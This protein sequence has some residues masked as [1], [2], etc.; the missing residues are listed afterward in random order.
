MYDIGNMLNSRQQQQKK[1][2]QIMIMLS[3]DFLQSNPDPINIFSHKQTR[4]YNLSV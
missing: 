3:K 1:P 4:A 2:K